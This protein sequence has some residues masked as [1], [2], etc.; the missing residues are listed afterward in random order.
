M[1]LYYLVVKMCLYVFIVCVV[2]RRGNDS[3]LGVRRLKKIL[4]EVS[5]ISVQ[6]LK[7]GLH[8]WARGVDPLFPVY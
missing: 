7:G 4:D 3:Q 6:D 5:L 2:C 1:H 8:G